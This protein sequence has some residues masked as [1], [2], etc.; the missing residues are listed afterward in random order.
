MLQ[1]ETIRGIDRSN[2]LRIHVVV[3]GL[4]SLAVL[5]GFVTLISI[6]SART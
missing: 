2:G 5:V 4:M 6:A 3:F 1:G